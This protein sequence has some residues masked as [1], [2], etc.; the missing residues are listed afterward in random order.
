MPKKP[1]TVKTWRPWTPGALK[2]L[3][4]ASK[5]KTSVVSVSRVLKRSPTALRQKAR[6]LGLGLG[7]QQRTKTRAKA[8]A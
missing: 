2:Y 8:R 5:K 7:P 1:A 4:T 3:K 6:E